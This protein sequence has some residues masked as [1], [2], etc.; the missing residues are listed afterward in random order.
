MY[1]YQILAIILGLRIDKAVKICMCFVDIS[2]E[3]NFI[4]V[5]TEI[6]VKA[7]V[8]LVKRLL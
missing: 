3:K 7:V 8:I 2:F 1:M 6:L 5:S 4:C